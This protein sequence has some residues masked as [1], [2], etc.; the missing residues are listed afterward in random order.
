MAFLI[1]IFFLDTFQYWK[2]VFSIVQGIFI[3]TSISNV[4]INIPLTNFQKVFFLNVTAL[5]L[6][7]D[8]ENN[9]KNFKIIPLIHWR[10][11]NYIRQTGLQLLLLRIILIFLIVHI[12]LL[13][14]ILQIIICMV[15][16]RGYFILLLVLICLLHF[17]VDFLFDS[18]SEF[19]DVLFRGEFWGLQLLCVFGL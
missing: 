7:K 12:W 10:R 16:T 17:F 8:F 18:I 6:I 14:L 11:I 1:L 4:A 2:Y 19:I 3:K 15:R 9:P 13:I 5:R